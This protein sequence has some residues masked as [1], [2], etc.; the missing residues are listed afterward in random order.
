MLSGYVYIYNS[1][2]SR[3]MSDFIY[4][5]IGFVGDCYMLHA[6][7]P[8]TMLCTIDENEG[9]HFLKDSEVES[10]VFCIS[11][12]CKKEV[13]THDINDGESSLFRVTCKPK[14]H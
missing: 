13:W 12:P 3:A 8:Q 10:I 4:G 5:C 7:L 1:L 14:M 9:L 6:S 11:S 2:A